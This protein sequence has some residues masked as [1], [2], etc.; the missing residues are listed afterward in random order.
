MAAISKLMF[1]NS[2]RKINEV[3]HPS[4]QHLQANSKYYRSIKF[5]LI[6][7]HMLLSGSS[8]ST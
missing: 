2:R 8:V 1:P 4:V 5:Y 7:H 6:I 3:S